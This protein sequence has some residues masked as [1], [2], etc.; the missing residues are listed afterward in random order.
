MLS[1]LKIH[2]FVWFLGFNIKVS[3]KPL[4][5]ENGFIFCYEMLFVEND[6]DKKALRFQSNGKNKSKRISVPL[7]LF[8][9]VHHIKQTKNP[10]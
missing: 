4:Q 9:E 6:E 1:L 2:H 3:R 7:G 10:G 5:K 8:V